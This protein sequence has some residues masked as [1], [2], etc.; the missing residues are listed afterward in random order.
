MKLSLRSVLLTS[1]LLIA[2]HTAGAVAIGL[3]DN[4][5]SGTTLSWANGGAGIPQPANISTGGPSGANDNFL[6]L[7]ADG[8]S[9]GG[10]LIVFNRDQW[11]GNYVGLGVTK[12]DVDLKNFGTTPLTIRL[13]FKAS[14]GGGSPGYVSAGFSLPVDS[15]WH[16]ASFDLAQGN[17]TAIG[18]PA[19]YTT[20][21]TSGLGEVRIINEALPLNLNGDTLV[22]QLGVDNIT[23]IPE[24]NA[25]AMIALC[26]LAVLGMRRM[27]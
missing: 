27:R 7:T 8:S 4:F 15:T 18:S 19:T 16:H 9:S 20:F 12:I 2:T 5:E 24:P 1:A 10:K 6:Q 17:L 13:A 14:A 11:L 25:M 23:A 21:F 26:G 22:S 3:T